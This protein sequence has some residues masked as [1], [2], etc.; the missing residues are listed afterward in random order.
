MEINS[1]AAGVGIIR[2]IPIFLAHLSS[3]ETT[4]GVSGVSDIL[5]L[6]ILLGLFL[7]G[8]GVYL[9]IRF[10]IKKKQTRELKLL[11]DELG[12]KYIKDLNLPYL[13]TMADHLQITEGHPFRSSYSEALTGRINGWNFAIFDGLSESGLS[14]TDSPVYRTTFLVL[15]LKDASF[16]AFRLE[17]KTLINRFFNGRP[18]A[19]VDFPTHPDFAKNYLL[20]GTD[21][22]RIRALFTEE[23]LNFFEYQDPLSVFACQS[24]LIIYRKKKRYPLTAFETQ[25]NAA[26]ET[27][28]LLLKNNKRPVKMPC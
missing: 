24:Y 23:V 5:V 1:L 17:P 2:E 14:G 9:L 16:P 20:H 21:K 6:F 10:Q 3:P 15:C 18:A 12:W 28:K 27:A 8:G 26:V 19:R 22:E 11:A 25:L 13:R 7:I 4:G